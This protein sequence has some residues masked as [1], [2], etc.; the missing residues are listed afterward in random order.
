MMSWVLWCFLACIPSNEEGGLPDLP[1]TTS[2]PVS[3]DATLDGERPPPKDDKPSPEYN[4]AETNAMLDA[5][6]AGEVVFA[7]FKSC[8]IEGGLDSDVPNGWFLYAWNEARTIGL[9]LSI[10]QFQPQDIPLDTP[11]KLSLSERDAFVMIEI[12]E[13]VDANFCVRTIQ[14]IPISTVLESQTGFVEIVK[15]ASGFEAVIEPVQFQDQYSKRKVNFGGLKFVTKGIQ[16][17]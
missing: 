4:T 3:A 9:V 7:H 1:G 13:Q 12:G 6:E 17:P 5:I 8:Q 16:K 2:P 15:T 10:H 11:R 14:Q